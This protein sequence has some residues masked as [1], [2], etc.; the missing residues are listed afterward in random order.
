MS[1]EL[2]V[3]SD[4][5]SEIN[6]STKTSRARQDGRM[7]HCND[8]LELPSRGHSAEPLLSQKAKVSWPLLHITSQLTASQS[9]VLKWT[10]R[11]HFVQEGNTM[12]KEAFPQPSSTYLESLI[13]SSIGVMPVAK[14]KEARMPCPSATMYPE[15]KGTEGRWNQKADR[16]LAV[17]QVWP[18]GRAAGVRQAEW[19][20]GKTLS[21]PSQVELDEG[22]FIPISYSVPVTD[23]QI[24]GDCIDGGDCIQQQSLLSHLTN[25]Y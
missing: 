13:F 18:K 21:Y 14:C 23:E 1:P 15:T 4:A 10:S 17:K 24:E 25:I 5:L 12:L 16:L 11:G 8:F 6:K 7:T 20:C 19:T 2:K 22:L 3:P 9:K